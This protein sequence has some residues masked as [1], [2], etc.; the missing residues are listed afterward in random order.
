M[1]L[2]LLCA[3]SAF[4]IILAVFESSA[5]DKPEILFDQLVPSRI[6]EKLL[7][8]HP[9]EYY[10]YA[11]YLWKGGKKDEALFW[12][13]A[14][15]LRYRFHL[16]ANPDLDKS[17]DPALFASLQE[18]LGKPINMYA[19][20]DAENWV[21]K[22]D[23]VLAWDAEKPNGFTSKEEHREEW[24]KVRK[25]LA[26]F[27]EYINTHQDELKNQREQ[28]G[29]GQVGVIDGVYVEEQKEKMPKDWPGL[30]PSD[31]RKIEG[32]YEATFD[33]LLGPTLFFA[34][35]YKVLRATSFE[36]KADEPG[37]LLVIAKENDQELLRR[38]IPI[39]EENDAVIFEE[40]RTAENLGLSQGGGKQINYLRV[41]AAGEL[42]IQ[43]DCTT[44]GQY[45]NSAMPV[46]Y[47]Y[48]FWNRAE[49]ILKE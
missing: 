34:D 16:K 11:A 10:K 30:L 46:R 43:R 45:P 7:N 28:N 49:R 29:V 38:K 35:Q 40:T 13:Y 24:E 27:K 33:A 31:I 20:S 9:S 18:M 42:I 21:R 32:V 22:I 23:D 44:E 12:F 48:T 19:G 14:G 4:L 1:R 6:E 26:D 8:E 41:N 39:R 36:L 37:Q 5:E 25:G 15:Q 2:G 47:S 3:L 17:G